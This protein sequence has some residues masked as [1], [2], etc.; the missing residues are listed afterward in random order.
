MLRCYVFS[1]NSRIFW[2]SFVTIIVPS[3]TLSVDL[4]TA[5]HFRTS[6][7]LPFAFRKGRYNGI[8]TSGESKGVAERKG[9]IA[10]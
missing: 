9:C 5:L 3:R 1:M 6:V 4:H 2:T 7:L 10:L 8:M